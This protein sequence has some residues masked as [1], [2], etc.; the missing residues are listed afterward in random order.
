MVVG[1]T[2][3]LLGRKIR[4][5]LD[6]GCGEGVWQPIL[7]RL[8]PGSRYAGVDASE[9]VVRRFGKRRNIRLGTFGDL[10]ALGLTEGYDLIVACDVLHYLRAPELR[11]GLAV[12]ADYLDGVAYLEAYTR[13]DVLTGD[14][15]GFRRRTAR[16]YRRMFHEAGLRPVGLQCYVHRD[17]G[18]TP[19][20]LEAPEVGAKP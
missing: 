14:M 1:I 2:E 9:Y 4:S 5:V 13:A 3:H 10:D 11:R 18:P 8:R 20:A 16:E 12:I 15:E 17:T 6:V 7:Q 19:T